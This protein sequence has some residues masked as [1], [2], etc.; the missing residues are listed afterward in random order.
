MINMI[1]SNLPLDIIKNI[2]LYDKRFIIRDKKIILISKISK[3]DKRYKILFNKIFI[4]I[5]THNNQHKKINFIPNTV[6]ITERNN[7]ILNNINFSLYIY[8]T[9]FMHKSI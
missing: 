1:F 4:F 9:I 6:V 5:Y 7:D 8:N 2:L 3:N